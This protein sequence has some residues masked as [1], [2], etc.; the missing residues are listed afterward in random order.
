MSKYLI[1]VTDTF[2]GDANYSWVR[3]YVTEARTI[4]GA[5]TKLAKSQG[6]GW[7]VGYSDGQSARYNLRG[8]CVCAFVEWIDDS[9]PLL[10]NAETI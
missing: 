4:R 8:A 1:E 5:I 10:A 2:G 7:K 6:A 3:R 9:H